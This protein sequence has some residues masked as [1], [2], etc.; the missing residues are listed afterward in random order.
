M[1]NALYNGDELKKLNVSIEPFT[2]TQRGMPT[3]SP[4]FFQP[5]E[6]DIKEDPYIEEVGD[7][8]KW[9]PYNKAY[10][11]SPADWAQIT[12]EFWTHYRFP[13]G[14]EYEQRTNF[15]FPGVECRE[16]VSSQSS[17]RFSSSCRWLADPFFLAYRT[18]HYRLKL[19]EL[20]GPVNWF[21]RCIGHVGEL[22][23]QPH[24]LCLLQTDIN[25]QNDKI[26]RGE[27]LCIFEMQEKFYKIPYFKEHIVFPI[28]F[29]TKY[30]YS[31]DS[32]NMPQ[33]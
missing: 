19:I 12:Y 8:T 11:I 21:S 17:S 5:F 30:K 9:F 14:Y 3:F 4:C 22:P 31:S 13:Q 10:D 25:G 15:E 6:G 7:L 33:C 2:L 27:L 20:N 23:E 1:D 18:D 24:F 29:T 16:Y 28:G 26:T 32:A